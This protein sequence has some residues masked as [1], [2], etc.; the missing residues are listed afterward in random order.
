VDIDPKALSGSEV[1]RL[2]VSSVVPRPIAFVTTTNADG[3]TNLAPFSYFNLVTSKPPLV[4]ICIGQRTWDGRKQKKDTLK[5]L[6]ALG[7]FVVNVATE[8]LLSVVNQ[9]SA[10][11]APGVS[12]LDELGLGTKASKVVSVA[13]LSE[14]PVNMECKV[15]RV[16][17]LGDEPQ[18]GMVVGEVVH[19]HADDRV[20][21][22]KQGG[23]DSRLLN[24]IARLGGT[25]YASLGELHSLARPAR[26]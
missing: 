10:D 20:W 21:D 8:R 9:S 16:V 4:S 7:E 2:M 26:P 25:Y 18:V 5:N 23:P 3:T 24:P 19:Y 22:A 1:Y 15:H 14:S 17:M 11:F 6:E 12:E 13:S